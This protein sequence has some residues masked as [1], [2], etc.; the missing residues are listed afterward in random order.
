MEFGVLFIAYS[1][2]ILERLFIHNDTSNSRNQNN[3]NS[4]VESK[5]TIYGIKPWA[6]H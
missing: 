2:Y 5:Y 1:F 3:G 6:V 4:G